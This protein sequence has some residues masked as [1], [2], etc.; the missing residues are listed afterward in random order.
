[1]PKYRSWKCVAV[2]VR[3]PDRASCRRL[4]SGSGIWLCSGPVERRRAGRARAR[5]PG[6]GSPGA[7]RCRTRRGSRRSCRSSPGSSSTYWSSLAA[8]CVWRPCSFDR[9][10]DAVAGD[11]H[12]GAG[13]ALL[14]L[15]LAVQELGD[16]L[17][18]QRA[19]LVLERVRQLVAGRRRRACRHWW[20]TLFTVGAGVA[21]TAGTPRVVPRPA[22]TT[23]LNSPADFF[24]TVP[25]STAIVSRE[26]A[27]EKEHRAVPE[28]SGAAGICGAGPRRRTTCRDDPS[29]TWMRDCGCSRRQFTRV[30]RNSQES[31]PGS[32]VSCLCDCT[33]S[34]IRRRRQPVAP[35]ASLI[36]PSVVPD[37]GRQLLVV[38][39]R[40]PDHRP[41]HRRAQGERGQVAPPGQPGAARRARRARRSRWRRSRGCARRRRGPA[42]DG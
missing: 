31:K 21:D 20:P 23:R 15:A 1:M 32:G 37:P 10:G 36:R 25:P 2:V 22:A 12:H 16:G 39:R 41:Q 7:A 4:R 33:F 14:D 6:R 24:R 19:A 42:R 38:A 18:A 9:R 30:T 28:P 11:L 34:Q 17:L 40:S 13:T 3:L 26:G 8:G 29:S 5:C 27:P 35:T